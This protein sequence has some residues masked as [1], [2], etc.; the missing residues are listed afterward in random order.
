MSAGYFARERSPAKPNG[1]RQLRP[2]AIGL[3][4]R[5]VDRT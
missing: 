3:S 5:F 4:Y 1:S 2:D